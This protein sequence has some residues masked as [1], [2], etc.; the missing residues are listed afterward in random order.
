QAVLDASTPTLIPIEIT[1][2]TALRRAYLP[3]LRRA[4]PLA[5]LLVRQAAAFAASERMEERYGRTCAGLPADIVNFL[6]DPLAVA[7]ALGWE[8]AVVER[9]PLAWRMDGDW[10]RIEER[11]DGRPTPLVTAVDGARFAEFWLDRV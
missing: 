4:G 9:V 5:A 3:A 11:P 10:L 1:E 2:R 8:G 6:H 7:I